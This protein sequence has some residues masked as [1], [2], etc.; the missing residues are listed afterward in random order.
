MIVKALCKN[1]G[2]EF[3][4]LK[5]LGGTGSAFNLKGVAMRIAIVIVIILVL[6]ELRLY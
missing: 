3:Y 5:E 6:L 2:Y 1:S 4:V